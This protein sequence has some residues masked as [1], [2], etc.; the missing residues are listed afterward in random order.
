MAARHLG[1][2][3]DGGPPKGPVAPSSGPGNQPVTTGPEGLA[4]LWS[5]PADATSPL[6][7]AEDKLIAAWMGALAQNGDSGGLSL[8]E[9]VPTESQ[10]AVLTP[11]EASLEAPFEAK[12][13]RRFWSPLKSFLST[14]LLSVSVS[15]LAAAVVLTLLSNRAALSGAGS[16]SGSAVRPAPVDDRV[17]VPGLSPGCATML[18]KPR[19]D[20]TTANIAGTCFS[21]G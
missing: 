6:A 5:L 17:L 7:A 4:D 21:V 15:A 20:G 12:V 14:I 16:P 8:Q 9:T 13:E 3:R 10:T 2:S 19:P 1:P 11:I 18:V